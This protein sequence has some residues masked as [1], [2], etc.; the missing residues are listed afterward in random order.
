M[1]KLSV[2]I[3]VYNV[4]KYLKRCLESILKQ[5]IVNYEIL[6]VDDGSTDSSGKICDSYAQRYNHIRVIHKEN[7]GLGLTRNVG[8]MYAQGEYILF[9]D[10]DDFIRD[11]ALQVLLE[12]VNSAVDICFFKRSIYDNGVIYDSGEHIDENMI[13][14]NKQLMGLCL[15]EPLRDDLIEIGPAWKALYNTQ[16][17]NEHNIQFKSERECLS[18]DYIFSAEVCKYVQKVA[19][20]DKDVYV[21]CN[22]TGSLTNSYRQ[23]RPEKAVYLYKLM[24]KVIQENDLDLTAA[25]RAYNNFLINLLV[26]FK[27]IVFFEKFSIKDKLQE[28]KEICKNSDI[29]ECLFSFNY[30]NN[31][32]MKL[33]RMLVLNNQNYLI[34][35]FIKLRYRG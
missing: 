30:S 25:Q 35:F 28:I 22:N 9:V 13:L 14:S 7:E 5:N 23:D 12:T 31:S 32:K 8:I 11:G 4:E 15:G 18:E 20:L 1:Y 16:F 33:L 26:S 17:L 6:L 19:Y 10:S 2:V 29:K 21:Y 27:H 34:Y 24:K 3:P